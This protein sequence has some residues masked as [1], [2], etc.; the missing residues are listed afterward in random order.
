MS[1][2]IRQSVLAAVDHLSEHSEEGRVS[3]PPAIAVV[4]GLRST[5]TLANG[6]VL[7]TDMPLGI[8]GTETAASPGSMFRA[9]AAACLASMIA[10]RAAT[11]Q[12]EL[13]L[14]EVEIGSESD[15]R[16]MLGVDDAVVAAPLSIGATVRI[17][18][19]QATPDLLREIVEWADAHSPVLDTAR[20]I[21]DTGLEIDLG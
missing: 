20:R 17:A 6:D 9:A 2:L 15:D 10:I 13:S 1:E 14:L 3:D 11:E 5:V 12:V 18:S 4:N 7:V 16:G 21:V 19:D 8:G